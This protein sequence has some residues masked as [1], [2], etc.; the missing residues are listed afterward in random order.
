MSNSK[1]LNF[2]K[3][4]VVASLI[5]EGCTSLST[6]Y[7]EDVEK[8]A[9]DVARTECGSFH[10]REV[11]PPIKINAVLTTYEEAQ[12]LLGRK[13]NHSLQANSK[14]WVV[15]LTGKW[16]SVGG[17]LRETT[18]PTTGPNL[19]VPTPKPRNVC[20]VI[21]DVNDWHAIYISYRQSIP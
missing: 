9:F 12:T 5:L 21:I 14:V 20:D 10:S 8:K 18:E 16:E 6:T 7:R 17:P 15:Q 13:L 4:I 1:H 3:F 2:F 11:E 19:P